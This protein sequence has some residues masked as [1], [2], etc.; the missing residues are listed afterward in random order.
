NSASKPT[1]ATYHAKSGLAFGILIDA[2]IVRMT[3]VPAVM[4]LV[5]DWAWW[6]PRH[7]DRRLPNLD[8]EG[9]KLRTTLDAD[10]GQSQ[11]HRDQ[12]TRKLGDHNG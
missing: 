11:Q 4:S 1:R 8:I 3:L 9:D 5:G 6:L 12:L 7:L 10:K 2:F